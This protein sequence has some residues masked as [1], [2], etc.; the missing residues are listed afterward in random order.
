MSRFV[1]IPAIPVSDVPD[2]EVRTLN[3]LKVNI[4]LLTAILNKSDPTRQALLKQ[5]YTLPQVPLPTI[6]SIPFPSVGQL[7]S[8]IAYDSS[9]NT[10]FWV[11][12]PPAVAGSINSLGTI[13]D[14]ERLRVDIANIRTSV[15]AIIQQFKTI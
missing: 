3:A 1:P 14:L 7:G 15:E 10:L 12:G 5:T 11:Q 4:E 9:G 2:W 6:T 8:D 13:A